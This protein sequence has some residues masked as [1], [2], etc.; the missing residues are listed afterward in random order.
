MLS[1]VTG[2]APYVNHLPK[3]IDIRSPIRF[4][5]IPMIGLGVLV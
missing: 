3:A 2:R 4:R 1:G 5:V